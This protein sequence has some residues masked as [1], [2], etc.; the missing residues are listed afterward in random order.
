MSGEQTPAT[1]PAR[2]GPTPGRAAPPA[3]ETHG[4]TRRFGSLTAVDHLDLMVPAGTVYG[5]LGPNGAGKSTALKMLTTLLRPTGGRACIMGHDLVAEPHRVRSA[6]GVAGQYASV[7]EALTGRENLR[8][9]ARLTGMSRVAARRRADEL[10]EAFGLTQAGRRLVRDYSGGM[11]RRLDLAVSMVAAPPLVFLDEPTTGLD[12]RTREQ[13][14][15][16]VE[17][18]VAL[19]TTVL[20]TTQYLEEADRLADRIGIIDHGR[21]IAEGT[22]DELKDRIGT[23]TLVL[24]PASDPAGERTAEIIAHVLGPSAAPVMR[25]GRLHTPITDASAAADVLAALRDAGLPPVSFAVDRPSLD[26]VFL[27]L[28][29]G[30][31]GGTRTAAGTTATAKEN[32]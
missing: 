25:A 29:Q 7:D 12:P 4:L 32:S 21:M 30:P 18:L 22:A 1:P 10:L 2:P 23:S 28:T 9:F 13:M 17:D 15:G 27:A 11:R 26:S 3:I 24:A 31:A 14:W 16:V 19:G 20:L 8:L 5:L 6:I